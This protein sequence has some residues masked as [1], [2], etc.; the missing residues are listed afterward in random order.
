MAISR[1]WFNRIPSV[2]DNR[3]RDGDGRVD[4]VADVDN[5]LAPVACGGLNSGLC[6]AA[7]ALLPRLPPLPVSR[8]APWMHGLG[9]AE[10]YRPHAQSRLRLP[11]AFERV[12]GS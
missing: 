6:L 7:Q 5:V 12:L 8:P 9:H 4:Q 3:S 2:R 1:S 10:P 11:M